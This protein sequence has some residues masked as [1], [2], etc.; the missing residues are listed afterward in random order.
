MEKAR[1]V[2]FG[3]NGFTPETAAVLLSSP[4]LASMGLL[5]LCDPVG[6]A[7]CE[8]LAANEHAARL[9]HLDFTSWEAR[10]GPAGA[11]ALGRSRMLGSLG[12]LALPWSPIGPDGMAGLCA[13]GLAR[14]E[15]LDV[16]WVKP[17]V[18]GV[19]ALVG[20]GMASRLRVLELRDGGLG[21]PGAKALAKMAS[22]RLVELDLTKNGIGPAGAKALAGCPGLASLAILRLS[23]NRLRDTGVKAIKALM[24]RG[25]LLHLNLCQNG[26][27]ATGAKDMLKWPQRERMALLWIDE[28]R[29]I[30]RKLIDAVTI[31]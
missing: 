4:R 28:A 10:I 25:N 5:S 16:N 20:S 6:D 29:G 19:E 23:E 27:T 7:G 9:L 14:L 3:S 11:A 21:D 26:L 24:R 1:A 15:C 12:T 17:E 2:R 8:A 22:G 13:G 31:R 30:R 18:R